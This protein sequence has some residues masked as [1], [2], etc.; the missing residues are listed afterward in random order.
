MNILSVEQLKKSFGER[1]LFEGMTFGLA[2]REKVALVARNGTGK[3]SLL[4]IL[5]GEEMPD[6]GRVVTRK[7]LR[8]GYLKQE[9]HFPPGVEVMEWLLTLDHPLLKAV[10]R[11]KEAIANPEDGDEMTNSL[12]EMDR[13]NGWDTESRLTAILDKLD[14]KDIH[15]QVDTLSG[16]Q[17]KR[18]ALAG[19]LLTEPDFLILD[20]P[21]NHLDLDMIEWLEE[22]LR[23]ASFA[24]LM[25]THDRYFLEAI[26]QTIYELDEGEL[27]KYDGNYSYY[28]EKKEERIQTQ[29]SNIEKAKNIYRREL[30]WIRSTPQARTTKSKSRI[31]SFSEVK[32]QAHQQVQ[33]KQVEIDVKME[34]LGS[35]ILELHNVKKSYDDLPILNK[36]SYT[37]KRGDRIGMVGKNGVGKSTFLRMIT[38]VEE[39]DA[40]KII[41]GETVRFGFYRQ[42]GMQM[43]EDKRVIEVIKEIAEVIPLAKGKSMTASQ[44]LERFL[45]EGD[46]QY[47]FVSKLSGGE[48]R[49]LYL[50]TILMSNPN[51]LILDEPTNDLDILTLNVLEDFLLDFQG[52][53]VIVSHDRY[54][55]DKLTNHLFVFKGNGEVKDFNG[56]YLEYRMDLKIEEEKKKEARKLYA[57]PTVK[58][59]RPKREKTKLSYKEEREFEAL[60]EEIEQL[61]NRKAEI[62]GIFESPDVDASEIEKLSIEMNQITERLDEAE[63]RWL[64]LSEYV[65]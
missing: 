63:M 15:A 31:D 17:R 14:L 44:L 30:E 46:Q 20:E 39:I 21:T 18:L 37:F 57:E 25:V 11:Y 55:L 60:T 52:C 50:L 23:E 35:K 41:T 51:F 28:L 9:P 13:L 40:G 56:N 12:A 4:R 10:I 53:L 29:R 5:A 38:Q 24:L 27:Y 59:A 61:E 6:D 16:G 8:V 47:T 42:D 32:K 33:N 64:E 45:F 65:E 58:D 22:W 34:R 7:G 36:F 43:S 19:L 3:T 26:C 54:F 62:A 48:K 2:E 49:R 1:V